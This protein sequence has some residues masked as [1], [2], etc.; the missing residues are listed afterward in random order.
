MQAIPTLYF[1]GVCDDALVF[2]AGAVGA[3]ILFHYRV[4]DVVDAAQ[5]K[6]GTGARTLRAGMRIGGTVLYLADAHRV[7]DPAFAGF[8]V[9]LGVATPLEAA[10][11][12]DALADG[13][14]VQMPLRETAW[15]A[16]YGAVQ[17][18]FGVHWIVEAGLKHSLRT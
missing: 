3:D 15:A 4:A 12:L 14:T 10:R 11:L 16:A 8:A 2:Y 17:D 5:I 18:R 1:Q 7:Q 9:T 6:A 13:G